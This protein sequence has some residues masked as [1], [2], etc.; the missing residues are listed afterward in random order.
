MSPLSV[1][2]VAC[3]SSPAGSAG[4]LR[5]A[6]RDTWAPGGS[7][8]GVGFREG[9]GRQRRGRWCRPAGAGGDGS[10]IGDGGEDQQA[11]TDHAA[12][13]R[14]RKSM[15]GEG[16][17]PEDQ[18]G[19]PAAAQPPDAVGSLV[20]P[21]RD[22]HVVAA[23]QSRQPVSEPPCRTA[24]RADAPGDQLLHKRIE[25][26]RSRALPG[27]RGEALRPRIEA[28]REPVTGDGEALVQDLR[29]LG[30]GDGQDD[31]RGTRREGEAHVVGLLEATGDWSGTAARRDRSGDP[32]RWRAA[33]SVEVDEVEDARPRATNARRSARAVGGPRPGRRR[34]STTTRR[35]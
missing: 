25:G 20:T 13:S 21:R 15:D 18:A 24:R 3:A 14:A 35:P 11:M 16:A 9:P 4:L 27:E 6:G 34:A 7:D 19:T 8:S 28:H 33:R 31:A 23:G 17:S 10:G 5:E 32:G 29:A 2:S 30:D 1:S 12:A 26:W 22:V